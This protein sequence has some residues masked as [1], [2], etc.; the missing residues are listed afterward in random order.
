MDSVFSN[1][2]WTAAR[3][4]VLE[5]PLGTGKTQA[6]LQWVLARLS[7]PGQASQQVLVLT[8]NPW[9]QQAVRHH[10]LRGPTTTGAL[11]DLSVYTFAGL[12]R[13]LLLHFWPLAE[14]TLLQRW[15]QRQHLSRIV[16]ELCGLEETA[17]LLRV[18]LPTWKAQN[19]DALELLEQS[20]RALI[21]Q[22]I[23]R[24]RQRSENR[25]SRDTMAR[26]DQQL[27][28][29]A[30]L[31]AVQRLENRLDGL[32]YPLRLLDSTRQLDV[33]LSLL[34]RE[35]QVRNWLRQTY[36]M[37]AVDDLDEA[38]PAQYRFIQWLLPGVQACCLAA[39][40]DGGSRQGYLNAHP[41]GW[42]AVKRQLLAQGAVYHPLLPQ[43]AAAAPLQNAQALYTTLRHDHPKPIAATAGDGDPRV[44]PHPLLAETFTVGALDSCWI[45]LCD[46]LLQRLEA[47]LQE[48][49]LTPADL[50]W[51]MPRMDPLSLAPLLAGLRRLG[52]PVQLLSGT[53]RPANDRYA[54]LWLVLVQLLQLQRWGLPLSSLEWRLVV[55]LA[56]QG[57]QR[58]PRAV[59]PLAQWLA[60]FV[61]HTAP[62][63]PLAQRL[64][65]AQQ[66]PVQEDWFDPQVLAVYPTFRQ[67]L[68]D[69]AEQPV[70]QGFWA[71]YGH[72]VRPVLPVSNTGQALQQL[73]KTWQRQLAIIQRLQLSEERYL[74]VWLLQAKNGTT[75][76]TGDTPQAIDPNA[77]LIGT[78]QK[79]IDGE[80][81]RPAQ[82]WIDITS[83]EWLRSDSAPLY[84]THLHAL[85]YRGEDTDTLQ[86]N[87]HQYTRW[88]VARQ[89]RKLLLLTTLPVTLFGATLDAQGYTQEGP[90]LP[91][92]LPQWGQPDGS[93]GHLLRAQL[94]PDQQP[95]LA[96]RSGTLAISAVPGAGKTFVTVELILELI[97]QG[98]PPEAILV[99]TYMDSAAR[100][101]LG[102]LKTKL[103][104]L[105]I[106]TLPTVS[107][108]HALAL[109]LLADSGETDE[110]L[111]LADDLVQDG[112]LQQV[113]HQLVAQGLTGTVQ[114]KDLPR[115]LPSLVRHCKSLGLTAH[116]LQQRSG[117]S[118]G[119]LA[120][121]LQTYQAR[122][123]QRGFMDFTDLI[124]QAIQLLEHNT[125]FRQQ[126]QQRYRYILEDEAQDSSLMLQRFIALVGGP[127]PN[128]VRVGDTNQSITTTF[129]TADPAVF[130][131]FVAQAQLTV[132]MDHSGR[133]APEIM[134]LANAWL[135][136]GAQDNPALADAFVPVS[137]QPVAQ[138]NP[139]LLTPLCVTQYD[140]ETEERQALIDHI[141]HWRDT[142]PQASM[143][144]LVRTNQQA[145]DITALLH[146]ANVPS[147]CLSQDLCRD[148]VYRTVLAYLRTFA[149]PHDGPVRVQWLRQL[150][151]AHLYQLD[152]MSEADFI[153]L[154]DTVASTPIFEMPLEQ[155]PP[156]PLLHPLVSDWQA[157][158]PLADSP[159]LPEVLHELTERL[160]T[161]VVDR[162]NGLLCALQARQTLQTHATLLTL[163]EQ[164]PNAPLPQAEFSSPL[165]RVLAAFEDAFRSRRGLRLFTD[166]ALGLGHGAAAQG[167]G[168]VQV[169]SL[170]KAKGQ[171]FDLVWMPGMTSQQLPAFPAERK[172]R[173]D[174]RLQVVLNRLA[175]SHTPASGPNP[176]HAAT[177][178]APM[179]EALQ[180]QQR[181]ILQE[182]ARLV[183]VGITRARR[184]LFLSTHAKG[185]TFGRWTDRTPA[186]A[187]QF[188]HRWLQ[189]HPSLQSV[190]SPWPSAPS[191]LSEDCL[192]S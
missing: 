32:A 57:W 24:Q 154:S 173:E 152:G 50:V 45:Q 138:Q 69:L 136:Q 120:T 107:T 68:L 89:L 46:T 66:L 16:P 172:L 153:T 149:Q 177:P 31:P 183:Y 84:H 139:S 125:L 95:V 101:L 65:T 17:F 156:L 54:R 85:Q 53:L 52:V 37:L 11:G 6:L 189:Q 34:S 141:T 5:G 78:P 79:V 83:R 94:R 39:D 185:R 121:A 127:Q 38:T 22:V 132:T 130:R 63:T 116:H 88:R 26:R 28:L 60:Q 134:A 190:P 30:A 73:A 87:Q 126:V 115:V 36:T 137:L 162:S 75:A 113:A 123:Q 47:T 164:D 133:C 192:P 3:Q 92:L 13:N 81:H 43:Q 1:P 103:E 15:P 167:A 41:A 168:V 147:V 124:W 23:R 90:L 21:N 97:Q 140:T 188:A 176:Q 171:E 9:R 14:E 165:E 151:E 59:A 135:H 158:Y 106:T 33:M 161:R 118:L 175:H 102:R 29:A 155:L 93:G 169:M 109:R 104:P 82:W 129:S 10:L 182:E 71:V 86:A 4:V 157:F 96:Y 187:W 181:A 80:I 174:E 184:G 55:G 7:E 18:L 64:P 100:T 42:D 117:Q 91:F 72:W 98:T 143:A 110:P 186:Y 20:D 146:S 44:V 61:Q 144:V 8:A 128:L 76:D 77:L 27:V 62:N 105:G 119:W 112:L 74:R 145:L 148:E 170:H 49:P 160:F 2:N 48:G 108:I 159:A 179:E 180:Q 67:T 111:T 19:P 191:P 166:E 114:A 51:V 163:L 131:Q 150:R 58:F 35:P 25:L 12:V 56:W 142:Q 40:A 70:E 99:L 178:A 122:L